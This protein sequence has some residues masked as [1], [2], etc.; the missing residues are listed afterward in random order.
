MVAQCLEHKDDRLRSRNRKHRSF[1]C[2]EDTEPEVPPGQQK[3]LKGLKTLR[4]TEDRNS[5]A[6]LDSEHKLPSKV[7]EELNVVLQRSRTLTK[8]SQDEQTLQKERK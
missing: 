3:G 6:T 5:K 7:I 2:L 8:E 4:R 1:N